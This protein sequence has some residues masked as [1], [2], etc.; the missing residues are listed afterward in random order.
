ME[1]LEQRWLAWLAGPANDPSQRPHV[2]SVR[3]SQRESR[4]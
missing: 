1:R 4:P 2:S 3:P